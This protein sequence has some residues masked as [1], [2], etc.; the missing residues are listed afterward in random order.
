MTDVSTSEFA[1]PHSPTIERGTPVLLGV[2]WTAGGGCLTLSRMSYAGTKKR[3]EP[4]TKIVDELP[5]MRRD[6]VELARK[7]A[8][9]NRHAYVPVNNRAEGSAPLTVQGLSEMLCS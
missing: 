9:E 8:A 1:P 4:Y 2:V 7:A 6:T 5:A 3:A